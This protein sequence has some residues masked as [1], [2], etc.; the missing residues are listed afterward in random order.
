MEFRWMDTYIGWLLD[1]N[2]DLYWIFTWVSLGLCCVDGYLM[3]IKSSI[4]FFLTFDWIFV[5]IA[6]LLDNHWTSIGHLLELQW[7]G[8]S[9]DFHG[10]PYWISARHYFSPQSRTNWGLNWITNWFQF[11]TTL[12]FHCITVRPAI[13]EKQWLS[14]PL[15]DHWTNRDDW[16]LRARV[17]LLHQAPVRESFSHQTISIY[18]ETKRYVELLNFKQS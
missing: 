11:T 12:L 14:R 6:W 16:L 2:I 8:H 18:Q 1:T 13:F 5:F 4:N 7:I 17:D 15:S 9:P 3:S 10:I